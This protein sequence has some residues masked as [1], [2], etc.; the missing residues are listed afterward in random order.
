MKEKKTEVITFRTT[1][2]VKEKL[3]QEAEARGWTIAKLTEIIVST[4][5]NENTPPKGIN[6]INIVNITQGG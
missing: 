6:N 4:Y 3:E 5:T 1:Q 2:K